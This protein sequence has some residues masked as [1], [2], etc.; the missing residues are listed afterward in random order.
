MEGVEEKDWNN[1]RQDVLAM[2]IKC[3]ARPP[4]AAG[5][6]GYMQGPL[7]RSSTLILFRRFLRG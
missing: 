3:G 1:K 4:S 5:D 6:I 7:P 2:L